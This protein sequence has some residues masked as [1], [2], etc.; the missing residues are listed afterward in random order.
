MRSKK[1]FTLI[2][3]MIVIAIIAIIAA[4]AIPGLLSSQRGANERNASGS[5]KTVASAEVDFRQNDRDGNGTNDFIVT[6]VR[7]LFYMMVGPNRIELIEMTIADACTTNMTVVPKAGYRYTVM[8]TDQNGAAYD[9]GTGRNMSRFGFSTFP[10]AVNTTGK[11]EFIINEGNT[12]WKRDSTQMGAAA[13]TVAFPLN[14]R[15]A[16]PPWGPMD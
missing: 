14:P 6:D 4:I 1:G 7:N 15:T 10:D 8:T 12:M 5:L 2:E 16:A 9:G 13:P 11:L 3:L